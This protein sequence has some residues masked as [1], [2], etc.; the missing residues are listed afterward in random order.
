[1]QM[2]RARQQRA[3]SPTGPVIQR[4]SIA[5]AGGVFKDDLIG[6]GYRASNDDESDT[7]GTYNKVGAKMELAFEPRLDLDAKESA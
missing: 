1:M 6:G 4:K 5:V 2:M 3:G 7:T